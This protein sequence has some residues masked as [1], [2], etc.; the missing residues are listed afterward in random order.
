MMSDYDTW[1]EYPVGCGNYK[2][3]K[4]DEKNNVYLSYVG[5]GEHK[6]KSIILSPNGIK[7]NSDIVLTNPVASK[8]IDLFHSINA[9]R[10]TSIYFNYKNDVAQNI[11]FRKAIDLLVDRNKLTENI[12]AYKPTSEFLAS[13]FWGRIEKYDSQNVKEAKALLQNVKGLDLNKSYKIPVYNSFY[14]NKVFGKY[15]ESLE[16]QLN[17]AGLKIKFF[18]SDEKFISDKDKTSLFKVLSMGADVVDPTVLFS[19]IR[20]PFKQHFP[21]SDKKYFELLINAESANSLDQR[22]IALKELSQY[23]YDNRFVVPLFERKS[24]IGFKHNKI[25]SLGEQN[26]GIAFYLDRIVTQ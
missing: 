9:A 8:N 15:L 25:K 12:S 23:M 18:N 24:T 21:E 1:K 16:Q 17:I 19:L 5:N 7:D 3:V 6:A 20:S 26:G 14:G 22:I 10:V 13:H 2:V 11:N 4:V